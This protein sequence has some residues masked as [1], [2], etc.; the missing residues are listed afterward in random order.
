MTLLQFHALKVWHAR[1][2]ERQPF[3]KHV[4]DL[5]LT[6]WLSGWV[7]APTALL[8]HVGWALLGCIGV[9]FLPGGYVR[10][11]RWLHRRRLVRCDWIVA[12]R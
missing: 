7:G 3:E 9:M 2:G 6:A 1:H 11:R 8:L 5:V 10:L 12:L 4:W